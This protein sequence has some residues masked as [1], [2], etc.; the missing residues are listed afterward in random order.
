MDEFSTWMS[1]PLGWVF[2]WKTCHELFALY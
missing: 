2:I 1:F